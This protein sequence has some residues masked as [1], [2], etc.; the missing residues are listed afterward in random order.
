MSFKRKPE[1]KKN[2]N[3]KRINENKYG[4]FSFLSFFLVKF[5][6]LKRNFSVIAETQKRKTEQ[7]TKRRR[8]H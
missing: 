2:R 4:F 7:R 1:E 5:C 8:R 3:E 6:S